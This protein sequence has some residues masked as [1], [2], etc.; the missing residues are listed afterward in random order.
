MGVRDSA[1]VH[2]GREIAVL[3]PNRGPLLAPHTARE[4]PTS[5][6]QS[7]ARCRLNQCVL[8][9]N[10]RCSM[11]TP[12]AACNSTLRPRKQACQTGGGEAI[13]VG[14]ARWAKRW[15][16]P[17]LSDGLRHAVSR[18]LTA[19]RLSSERELARACHFSAP[20]SGSWPRLVSRR[21]GLLGRFRRACPGQLWAR[22]EVTAPAFLRRSSKCLTTRQ[23]V[24][25]GSKNA[26]V[27]RPS[28]MS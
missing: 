21:T 10:E 23:P 2:P 13:H 15:C 20:A 14:D 12:G 4:P 24:S 1:D 7:G 26:R 18:R 17:A 19:F 3:A 28:N 16:L 11:D 27:L 25:G 5:A 6:G 8:G 22:I 9:D